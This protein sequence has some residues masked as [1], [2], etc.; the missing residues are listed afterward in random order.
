MCE[1]IK[2]TGFSILEFKDKNNEGLEHKLARK[3]PSQI[4][5][6]AVFLDK[7]SEMDKKSSEEDDC[8]QILLTRIK[9]KKLL[10]YILD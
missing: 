2:L 3:W 4:E 9:S 5:D 7:Q 10:I 1:Y 6:L 8:L